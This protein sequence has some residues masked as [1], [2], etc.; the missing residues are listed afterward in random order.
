MHNKLYLAV[1]DFS[2]LT[3]QTFCSISSAGLTGFLLE[4]PPDNIQVTDTGC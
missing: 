3:S 2:G 1:G 4:I